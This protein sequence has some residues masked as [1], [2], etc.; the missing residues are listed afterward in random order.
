MQKR[1]RY[2]SISFI[3]L[4]ASL[5][6]VSQ[7]R[8]LENKLENVEGDEKFELL[9]SIS[10]EYWFTDPV[11]SVEFAKEAFKIG[12]ET[13]NDIHKARALNRIANGYYFLEQYKLSLEYYNKSLELS[14]KTEYL[15]GIAKSTNN[16]GLI[17][18]IMGDYDMAVE[19]YHRSLEIEKKT[20]N[21]E[22]IANTSLNL[23]N[24]YH[25]IENYD[26]AL[27]L[28][29]QSLIIFIE[30]EDN[31]GILNAYTNLGSTYMEL[32]HPD[33]SIKYSTLAYDLSLEM[34]NPDNKASSLNN[35]GAVYVGKGKYSK[36][37]EFFNEA[38]EIERIMEDLWS[39]ANTLRNIGGVYFL[40]KDYDKAF[41]FFTEAIEIARKIGTK[42]ILVELYTDISNYYEAKEDYKKSL[43]YL[44]FSS[45]INDSIFSEESIRQIAEMEAKYTFR[46]KDQQLQLITKENE[47]KSLKIKSQQYVIYIVASISFLILAFVFIF[48]YRARINEKARIIL[49]AKNTE[50]TE[51]KIVLEKTVAELKESEEKQKSLLENINDGIFI[52]QNNKLLYLNEAMSKI[53]GYSFNELYDMGFKGI[54]APDDLKLIINSFRGRLQGK[55]TISSYEFPLRHKNQ[56]LIFVMLSIGVIN[57]QGKKAILGTLKDVTKNKKYQDEI[58]RAKE[59]AEN[60]TQ[61]KSMFLAGMSHEIRNHMNSIIGITEVLEETTLNKDQKEYINVINVSGNNLLSIINEILDFSKIEAGQI[62]LDPIEFKLSKVVNEVLSMHELKAKKLGLQLKSKISKEIP[63]KLIGD[64]TRLSQILINLVSNAIKFTDKGSITIEVGINDRAFK[65]IKSNGNQWELLFKVIDTGIGLSKDSQQKLFKPFSQTHAAVQRKNGGTGLGLAI[66]KQLVELMEGEIGIES[67]VGKGSAF[68]FSAK[69][70]DPSVKP[71]QTDDP[72]S[73]NIDIPGNKLRVLIVED[74]ILNQ[75]V[76]NSLL[77]KNGFVTDVAEN[78][79]IGLELFKRKKYDI[80]LMDIQ[81]PVMDGIKAT[82]LIRKYESSKRQKKAKIIAVTAHTKAGEQQELYNAGMDLYLSKPFKSADLFKMIDSLNLS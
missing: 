74:N 77:I 76:T 14:E 66:C 11:K 60:A 8:S 28:F 65:T 17:F 34:N 27:G 51:Q 38:L 10:K 82:R 80:V 59:K 50:I 55:K 18:W 61:S 26:K 72:K 36:A 69:F 81:M 43:E 7:T 64:S 30:T 73:Q 63:R 4:L 39:E 37:L 57:F 44:K 78:G 1:L 29:L 52:I 15:K 20:E 46:N 54:I 45:E 12:Q 5:L 25:S 58:I 2:Y 23:G 49:E 19:Y 35:L 79:K 42:S 41:T 40:M 33:S 6:A 16:I 22:G 53:T 47:V 9:L 21:I 68:W 56:H 13:G 48:Y 3:F 67:E 24:I 71:K 32:N 62:V 70:I 31:Q 75:Q